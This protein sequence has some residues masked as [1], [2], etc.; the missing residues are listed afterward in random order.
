MYHHHKDSANKIRDNSRERIHYCKDCAYYE[1]CRDTFRG[2]LC[3]FLQLNIFHRVEHDHVSFV[4]MV[5][6]HSPYQIN[7]EFLMILLINSATIEADIVPID[8]LVGTDGRTKFHLPHPS[9]LPLA[10]KLSH[11]FLVIFIHFVL[12]G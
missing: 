4:V 8:S 7:K 9:I 12:A 6:V 1:A 10:Q 5:W 11:I 3:N 2:T